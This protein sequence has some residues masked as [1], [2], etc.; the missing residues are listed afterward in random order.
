MVQFEP[1]DGGF[2]GRIAGALTLE[3]I[4]E[5]QAM[6]REHFGSSPP[7]W[8]VMD[9]TDAVPLDG[10]DPDEQD[11]QVDN[12]NRVA[13]NLMVIRRDRFRLAVVGSKRD[14]DEILALLAEARSSVSQTLPDRHLEIQR[15]DEP[16]L[17][18]A[19]ARDED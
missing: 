7:V 3:K 15:F 10:I 12:V 5:L 1:A 19:W 8:A 13:R 4:A 18:L 9:F 2:H 17:A 11:L 16:D 14:F 6:S